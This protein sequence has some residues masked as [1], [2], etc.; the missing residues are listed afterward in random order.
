MNKCWRFATPLK[1]WMGLLLLA[2]TAGAAT[3]LQAESGD[4]SDRVAR[5][6][7]LEG[8]VSV[9]PSG[10]DQWSQAETNYPVATG[11]RIYTDQDGRDEL[12]IGGVV[13]RMWHVTDL[14]MT[15]LSDQLTQLGLAQGTVRLRTFGLDPSQQVE[16]DTP[17]G[18]ITVTQPGDIRIDSFEGDGGTQ[19]TVNSGAV[20]VTGPNLS[21][22]VGAGTSLR[23]VGTNP[24]ELEQLAMPGLDEF[25]QFSIA[26]DRHI[27]SSPSAQYVSRMTPGFDDLDDY[28]SWDAGT[29]YGPVWYP[30]QVAQDWVPYREGHWVWTGPWGWT[31]VESEPWGYA[32]FH[33]GRWAYIGSR[34]GWVPGPVA[35]RPFWSPALVVFAGG[36]GFG[37]GLTAWFPLGVGEPFVPWYHCSPGYIRQINVTNINITRIHNTTI[38]NNYNNFVRNTN[39]YTNISNGNYQYSHRQQGFTAAPV[40]AVASGQPINRNLAQVRP[41]QIRSAQVIAHPSIQPIRQSVVTRPVVHAVP[42]PAQRPTLL[43]R[44]GREA[45]A[46]AGS[47]SQAVPYH[48]LPTNTARGVQP[49]GARPLQQNP[50]MQH[51]AQQN[52]RAPQQPAGR[53]EQSGMQPSRA[54]PPANGN[55]RP[56]IT[57]NGTTEPVRTGVPNH[58]Q[59]GAGPANQN[60]P[61]N[62]NNGYSRPAMTS[63][64]NS[65]RGSYPARPLVTHNEAP[66]QQPSFQQQQRGL[67]HDPGRPLDPQQRE[68]IQSGRTPGP[69]RDQEYFPHA[70]QVQRAP[71]PQVRQPQSEPMRAPQPQQMRAP[72]PQQQ[73]RS[74]PEPRSAPQAAPRGGEPHGGGDHHGR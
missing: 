27:E 72:Q 49:G 39:N 73:M 8:T 48:A 25:D 55:A 10:V 65:N 12:S 59:P 43:T 35:V 20:Q 63:N 29:E 66:A 7:Y 36:G 18:A 42:V 57:R 61:L 34:W 50:A 16:V 71:Q 17:N 3:Q 11:D 30:R 9:Q 74:A 67:Q 38:I 13:V 32:P 45:Q 52:V 31:W 21:Q 5:L 60:R 6:A 46:V 33:Y 23:L 69:S 14:T 40:R 62:Q 15:N 54:N 44:G 28:G 56:L 37:V 19:L 24:V 41:E 53:P 70:Q 4:P 68:T 22:N 58:V 2:I 64:N 47:H 26:R 1:L 51:P